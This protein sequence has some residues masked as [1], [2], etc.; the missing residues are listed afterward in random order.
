MVCSKGQFDSEAVPSPCI[1]LCRVDPHTGWCDGCLRT[2]DEISE[3]SRLD[4]A[5]KRR[6]WQAIGRRAEGPAAESAGG[7]R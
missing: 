2:L 4:E 6:V 7:L 3:W 5:G 1:S